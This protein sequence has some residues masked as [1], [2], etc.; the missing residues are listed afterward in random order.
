MQEQM[1]KGFFEELIEAKEK[2]IL[3]VEE[4]KNIIEKTEFAEDI[5]NDLKERFNYTFL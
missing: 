4:I 2:D 3:S 1:I 5:K